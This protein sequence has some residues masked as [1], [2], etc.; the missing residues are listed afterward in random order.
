MAPVPGPGKQELPGPGEILAGR[1]CGPRMQG[2]RDR[3]CRRSCA[4]LCWGSPWDCVRGKAQV[5]KGASRRVPELYHG[6]PDVPEPGPPSRAVFV[7]LM[8]PLHGVR[9]SGSGSLISSLAL[10]APPSNWTFIRYTWLF[11]D[12]LNGCSHPSPACRWFAQA[13]SEH[14]WKSWALRDPGWKGAQEPLCSIL[15]L[16]ILFPSLPTRMIWPPKCLSFPWPF[17]YFSSL[18]F[19]ILDLHIWV[20]K[21]TLFFW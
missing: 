14:I 19:Y 11:V 12:W 18:A 1:C 5:Q 2:G 10:L 15:S 16:E 4:G 21:L 17:L 13:P 20:K 8:L 3:G 7:T 9:R 6:C